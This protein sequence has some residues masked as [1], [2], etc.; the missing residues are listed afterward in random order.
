MKVVIL[1]GG[2]GSRLGDETSVKPK[3]MVEIGDMPIL[4]HIMKIYSYYGFNDFII[5]LGYKGNVIKEYFLNYIKYNNNLRITFEENKCEVLQLG[6]EKW[7]V[8]LVD[9]G[10]NTLTGK[11][12]KLAEK[13]IG[14][15]TFLLTY[16]DGLSNVNINKLI[17]F[18]N[19]KRKIL[20][21]TDVQP[22]G[23]FGVLSINNELVSTFKEKPTNSN[24]WINGGFFVCEPDI[25]KYLSNKNVMFEDKIMNDLASKSEIAAYKH[26]GF[27]QCMDTLSDKKKLENLIKNKQ[28]PWKIWN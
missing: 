1:A 12:I 23:R 26:T 17:T 15:E 6:K 19:K 21:L 11:R 22:E 2:Y 5:L 3:P 10:L 25:F 7:K 13:F 4:W 8:D 14:N 16:G 28:A 20:T 24:S 18:H 9:T 27:W